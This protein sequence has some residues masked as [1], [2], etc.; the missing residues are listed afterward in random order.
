MTIKLRPYESTAVDD[1]RRLFKKHRRLVAVA[2]TGSG[3]TVIAAALVKSFPRT[4]VLWIA[5]RVELLRQ[6]RTQL[7][8]AGVPRVDII[9]GTEKAVTGAPVMVA[10]I[11]MFRLRDVPDV[12]LIVV[13]E[14]HR[15]A[16]KSYL[17]LLD[18][19]PRAKVLGLTATPW[20]LDG[21]GLGEVF[22]N[23]L[24]MAGY[25]ELMADK[26]I[27]RP[28]T[29]GVPFAKALSMVTGVRSSYGDYDTTAL[30]AA[31]MKHALVGDVV[32]EC[33]RLAPGKPT[34]VFAVSRKHAK[35][36]ARRFKRAGRAVEY[37][38]AYTPPE[39]RD[40]TVARMRTGETDVVVNVDVFSEGID[41]P[42]VK[43]I[44]MA[45]PTRSLTRFLQYAG[46]ASRPFE[47]KRPIVLDHAG[48]CYRHGLPDME[49][50]WTLDGRLADENKDRGPLVRICV[51]CE[52][53]ISISCKVCP[54]CGAEQPRTEREITEERSALERLKKTEA[55]KKETLSRLW[56]VAN[57]RWPDEEGR[58]EAWVKAA[59]RLLEVA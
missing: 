5:H 51:E 14:A 35:R 48:N 19:C 4:R 28:I 7:L 58:G 54:E 22:D 10:S 9:S 57:E 53:M 15:I 59:A 3:K 56:L 40:A 44:V 18:A 27:A 32:K 30:G 42:P 46:R 12:G 47:G 2:P 41:C 16:A 52:A 55:Q 8:L 26:Y 29:Y 11:G 20:R 49:R 43:C 36:L 38:D 37:V 6:A 31:M 34:L 13:D 39:D 21:Q 24:S 45:R 50:E 1:L 17:A 23:M 33:G 25:A